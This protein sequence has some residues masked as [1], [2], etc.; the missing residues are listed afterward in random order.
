MNSLLTVVCLYVCVYFSYSESNKD[1]KKELND[2][3]M[4]VPKRQS[5]PT[6]EDI[7]P[8]YIEKL[9]KIYDIKDP[10]DDYDSN[11][12]KDYEKNSAASGLDYTSYDVTEDG[13]ETN[14]TSNETENAC[15]LCKLREQDKNFRL[16]TI[17]GQILNKLGFSNSKLPNMTGKNFPR[18]PSLQKIIDQYEM[19]GD[20]PYG[21][22]DEY[23]P[24]DEYYGQVQRAY[25]ISQPLPEKFKIN[26]QDAVY[27]D[28]P[29]SVTSRKIRDATL[30]VY[31]EKPKDETYL[32]MEM[33]LYALP[34]KGKPQDIFKGPKRYKKATTYGWHEIRVTH[35]VHHWIKHSDSNRGLLIQALDKH[36]RN[37]VVTPDK[38]PD[39]TH[40]PM[41]EMSTLPYSRSHRSKRSYDMMIC[42]ESEKIETCCRY[43]LRVNFVEFGWDWVIAPTGYT[44]NY[45]SG[46]CR[47]RHVENNPQA[48]LIQQTPGGTGPCCTPSKMLPLAMLYF[49]HAH[50]VL[51]TYM[52]KMV[53][54]RC[55]C[56]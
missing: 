28:L 9:K 51:Y 55:G 35:I 15:S 16:D 1:A 42:S 52:Q 13:N 50:T 45:C 26:F 49:D 56:A 36:G 6:K 37:L 32:P 17:K 7:P 39:E 20:Q 47:Y 33:F 8:E 29:E 4:Y 46:E 12:Y 24:E 23:L 10:I 34:R 3:H 31:V 14:D 18:T 43:P 44:A 38:E 30:W 19:Q 40:H 48:Y 25:T 5:F 54:V 11:A 27:F 22:M 2:E 21:G 41:L 53:V